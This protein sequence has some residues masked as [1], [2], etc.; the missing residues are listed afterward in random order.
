MVKDGKKRGDI[1]FMVKNA[2]SE[3]QSYFTDE[4]NV[5]DTCVSTKIVKTV[6]EHVTEYEKVIDMVHSNINSIDIPNSL[7]DFELT[8]LC[9]TYLILVIV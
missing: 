8:N 7:Y 6:K 9:E 3:S 5:L 4:G 2:S 1:C